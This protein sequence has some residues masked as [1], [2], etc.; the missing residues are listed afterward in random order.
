MAPPL[1]T[2]PSSA[3]SGFSVNAPA[4]V[5]DVPYQQQ[6]SF[7]AEQQQAVSESRMH[8]SV[9]NKTKTQPVEGGSAQFKVE[10][11]YHPYQQQQ[12]Q[13]DAVSSQ[14]SSSLGDAREDHES[15][16]TDIDSPITED[17]LNEQADNDESDEQR[18]LPDLS[19]L[20]ETSDYPMFYSKPQPWPNEVRNGSHVGN[21]VWSG[22][23]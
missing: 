8:F 16:S 10:Q 12:Q 14:T 18:F 3:F 5:P 15:M 19:F 22:Y 9:S 2:A 20:T 21:S 6:H 17:T 4:F 1:T 7:I 23:A 11:E 13:F